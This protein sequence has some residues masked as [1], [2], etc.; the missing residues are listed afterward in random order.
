LE[1]LL[2]R[3]TAVFAGQTAIGEP[4]V[5]SA[6]SMAKELAQLGYITRAA[7]P[8]LVLATSDR[9]GIGK[10]VPHFA[11]RRKGKSVHADDSSRSM[12]QQDNANLNHGTVGNGGLNGDNSGGASK[13]NHLSAEIS[14][15]EDTMARCLA[16]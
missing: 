4:P 9:T 13:H 11:A 2:G 15:D 1:E 16:G 3:L 6:C 14:G 10:L 12:Q 8:D 7:V 5:V